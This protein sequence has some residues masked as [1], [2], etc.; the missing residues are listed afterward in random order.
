[1]APPVF[2]PGGAAGPAAE[3]GWFWCLNVR[4]LQPGGVAGTAPA[5]GGTF[6]AAGAC[7]AG[8]AAA[9]SVGGGAEI[10][11]AEALSLEPS[12]VPNLQ[13]Q[14]QQQQSTI[15]PQQE[16]PLSP[17]LGP[18]ITA[19]WNT[20]P[21]TFLNNHDSAWLQGLATAAPEANWKLRG[22]DNRSF[23]NA[24]RADMPGL[25]KF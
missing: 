19:F 3:E 16:L 15:L 13:Q 2:C 9:V 1:M 18:M 24:M 4:C 12:H 11:A 23:L 25:K 5:F 17:N 10:A 22:A 14:Q 21:R 6:D 20:A 7:A 8:T